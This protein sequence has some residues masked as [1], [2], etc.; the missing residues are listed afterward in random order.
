MAAYESIIDNT[1]LRGKTQLSTSRHRIARVHSQVD[2]HLLELAHVRGNQVDIVGKFGDYNYFVTD[3]S[4]QYALKIS[5]ACVQI[6]SRDQKN[7][8]ATESQELASKRRRTRYSVTNCINVSSARVA[9]GQTTRKKFRA[10][11]NHRQNIVEIVCDARCKLTNRLHLLGMPQL[12]FEFPLLRIVS[13]DAERP[14]DFTSY[15]DWY[16]C[17]V[18]LDSAP[19]LA[20]QGQ[21]GSCCP[22]R[23]SLFELITDLVSLFG[24]NERVERLPDYFFSPVTRDNL[25]HRIGALEPSV[26][27][28]RKY[29]VRVE[30]IKRAIP[31]LA[32]LQ[33]LGSVASF[34]DIEQQAVPHGYATRKA[35]WLCASLDPLYLAVDNDSASPAP[36]GA[37]RQRGSHR[38]VEPRAIV[39]M[40]SIEYVAGVFHDRSRTNAV[41]VGCAVANVRERCPPIRLTT[42][43][44]HHAGNIRCHPQKALL[45]LA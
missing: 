23:Q 40:N 28:Q 8:L 27:V 11:L 4:A 19:A 32:D 30:F 2:D 39:R 36:R 9:S 6:Y 17:D 24:N 45:A 15:D 38:G 41:D 22:P 34:G 42:R 33:P 13:R 44:I 25:A 1:V 14:N 3:H 21:V 7:L 37:L 16:G 20:I 43:L 18:D 26:A 35:L 5:Q 12:S 29:C 31:I 10:A